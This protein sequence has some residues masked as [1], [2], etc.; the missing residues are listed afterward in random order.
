[1]RTTMIPCY[2]TGKGM[3]ASLTTWAFK[4]SLISMLGDTGLGFDTRY[5][6]YRQQFPAMEL[7][8]LARLICDPMESYDINWPAY[9]K[10]HTPKITAERAATAFM[11]QLDNNFRAQAQ[12]VVA[13]YDEAGFGSGINTMVFLQAGKPILGFYNRT[14]L[15]KT[16]NL[17]N[18][19]QLEITHPSLFTLHEY[20]HPD[21]I[22]DI[23]KTW[24]ETL[25]GSHTGRP[26]TTPSE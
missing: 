25:Q 23:A 1:M 13:C 16:V 22:P 21:D 3:H 10:L 19:L 7:V 12:V 24:L 5:Q 17:S 20:K 4:S 2:I 8:P 6:Y 18:I 15:S 9:K 26:I 11:L 14:V